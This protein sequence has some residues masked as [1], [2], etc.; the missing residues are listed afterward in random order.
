MRRGI[1]AALGLASLAPLVPGVGCGY[2]QAGAAWYLTQD[3]G[4]KDRASPNAVP[5][6]VVPNPAGSQS[7]DVALSY[8]LFDAEGNPSDIVVEQAS[9]TDGGVTWTPFA[10]ASLGI[11]PPS[12]GTSGL[13]ASPAGAPHT[14]V[15]NSFADIGGV[16]ALARVR[17][18]PVDPGPPARTGNPGETAVSGFP[19][20]NRLIAT[21]LSGGGSGLLSLP[22][23]VARDGAGNLYVADTFHHRVLLLNA[24][25]SAIT[26]AGV[27]VAPNQAAVLAGTGTPGYGGDNVLATGAPLNFPSGVALDGSGNVLVADSLNHRVR[28]VDRTTG[29]ITTVAG[30]GTAGTAG[31]GGLAT[32]AQVNSPRGIAFDGNGNL[33]VADT[34]NHQ[35]RVVNYQTTTTSFAGVS[36]SPGSLARIMGSAFGV[37][38]STGDGGAAS[39]PTARLRSPWSVAVDAGGDV[40]VADS[41][42]H[43]IRVVNTGTT[44]I[45]VAGV[46]IAGGNVDNVAGTTGMAG[47][48][49]DNGPLASAALLDT[50]KG[51]ALDGNGNVYVAD[52]VNSRLRVVNAQSSSITLASVTISAS[53]IAT[54]AGGGTPAAND[55]DGGAATAARL[56]QP[57]GVAVLA[58][59]HALLADTGLGRVRLVNV[60]TTGLSYAGASVAGGAIE[61]VLGTTSVAGG[62]LLRPEGVVRLGSLLFVA[63]RDGHR[64]YELN[65]ATGS[66]ATVAGTGTSGFSGDGG[67]AASAQV[68]SPRGLALDGSGNLYV[69]DW[70]NNRVRVVNRQATGQTILNVSVGAGAIATVAGGGAGG[71]GSLATAASVTGSPGISLD[72]SGNLLIAHAGGNRVRRVLATTG[73]ISTVAGAAT[74]GYADGAATGTARFSAPEGVS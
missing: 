45:T 19:V 9:S 70:G 61:S 71:D 51:V 60:G 58:G 11:G 50:P 29:F 74:A 53:R 54:V 72:A 66:L 65:L 22:G 12:E 13:P 37:P 39:G 73:V 64:V 3:E 10:A 49:G 6:V 57:E 14:V 63:D 67:T 27:T 35:L 28:R 40:Y 16:N 46:P 56:S 62:G 26:V 33:F 47:F 34:G 32:S 21:V 23:G 43:A 38:G 18:T 48:S 24:Q 41:G 59:G 42:N 30:T 31:D 4:G 7:G 25:A 5:S 2:L 17:I 68:A 15:W 8:L 52:T 20:L 69:A 44:G 36:V 55:G 1:F